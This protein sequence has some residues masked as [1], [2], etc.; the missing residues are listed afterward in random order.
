M[1]TSRGLF[2]RLMDIGPVRRHSLI[3]FLSSIGVTVIGFFATIYIAHNAGATALGGFFLLLAYVGIIGLFTVVGVIGAALQRIAEGNSQDEYFSAHAAV[4]G[5]L[6]AATLT[7]LV[8]VR[9][10]FVDLNQSGLFLWLIAALVVSTGAGII[11]TGV[12]GSGK[13]GILQIAD[14]ANNIIRVI[15]Q[16]VAV[17][18]G[19][20]VGGLAAGFI[21]G[22]IAGLLINMRVLSMKIVAFG[23]RNVRGLLAFSGWAFITGLTGAL[24]GYADTILVGYF[25]SN[26]EIGMYRTSFQLATIALF[27]MFAL[28]TALYPKIASWM[29]TGETGSVET[30]LARAIT[31]SLALA[32]PAACGAWVLGSSLLYYLYG[33]S[34][35]AAGPALSLLFMVELVTVFLS[36]E[37]MCLGALDMPKS[38]F[39]VTAIGA[40]STIL[41]DIM[42]IPVYGITG[43]ALALLLGTGIFAVAAHTVLKKRIRVRIEKKPV[44]SIIVSSFVMAICVSGYQYVIP[45][46]N[47]FLIAGAVVTGMVVYSLLL[48]RL[49]RGI[50]D[51]VRD[52]VAGI[53]LPWP[54]WL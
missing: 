27:V 22:I 51:E 20:S 36:L 26:S 9:P 40:A 32:L 23:R 8:A 38:V 13:V 53:G 10:L 43:A 30:A 46:T 3:A 7:L 25:L 48:V 24:M 19:Y 18:I 28:R 2:G 35:V 50:R 34:F 31:Y 21:A 11:S 49:D 15:V 29:K 12:Y 33:A 1:S 47:V 45:G 54:G 42:L 5:I 4:R 39:L 44:A 41:L 14:L 17:Y 16:V 37:T 6:L 52:L